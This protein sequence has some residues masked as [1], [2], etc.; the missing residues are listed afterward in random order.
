MIGPSAQALWDK[1]KQM[2]MR[3]VEV[4]SLILQVWVDIITNLAATGAFTRH[5]QHLQ[6]AIQTHHVQNKAT[7]IAHRVLNRM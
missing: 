7:L 3:R 4:S 5:L 1:T 6:G 2:V